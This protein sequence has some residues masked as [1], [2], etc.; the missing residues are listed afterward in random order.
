MHFETKLLIF[1]A[2]LILSNVL[3]R[4]FP[5]FPLPFIQ[6]LFGILLGFLH[7]GSAFEL[8]SEF[9]LAFVIAPINFREAQESDLSSFVKHKQMILYLILP[10]VFVTVLGLGYVAGLV[11][12]IEIPLAACFALGAALAPTDA[13]AF[14][15]IA[16]RFKFP[17]RVENIL[18]SEGLLN[19]ASGL[20]A[21]Q[22]A[23]AAMLTGVFSITQASL[24]LVWSIL[25]GIAVGFVLALLSR[26]ML[27]V[28]EKF[29]AADVTG[30]LFLEISLPLMAYFLAS[31]LGVSGIIAVVIAGVMQTYRMKKLTLFDVRVDQVSHTVWDTITFLLNGIVFIVFG[32]ELT[33]ILAPALKSSSFSNWHLLGIVLLLTSM[34][35]LIRF[36]MI[37]LF[38]SIRSIRLKKRVTRYISEILLLT[39]SGVKGTVSI[40]TILLLPTMNSLQYSLILF[41]VGAVTL[42]S[43]VT[44]LVVLPAL[45]GDANQTVNCMPQIAILTEVI[46][47]LEQDIKTSDH[48]GAIYAT[49]DNYK[50]RIAKLILEQEP[51][52][53]KRELALIQMMII[54]IETEGLEHALA[55]SQITYKE[56]QFYQFYI[57]ALEN[58]VNR[59]F[60]SNFAYSFS[61]LMRMLRYSSHSLAVIKAR[62]TQFLK[63]ERPEPVSLTKRN[64]KRLINLYKANTELVLDALDELDGVYNASLVGFFKLSRLQEVEMV[65]SDSM[66]ERIILRSITSHIDELL[67]GYYLERKLISEHEQSGRISYL[68]AREL[69][70]NVNE[71][72]SYSL[73]EASFERPN[74]LMKRFS[75]NNA[76]S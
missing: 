16:N 43:F 64:K 3:N 34:L 32:Y 40:A 60:I 66:I 55:T 68:E 52:S 46:E 31:G 59:G 14:I 24:Q 42:T 27:S 38:Y 54:G 45:A 28:L 41:I 58:R 69:R 20:V 61:I 73:K 63:Q 6:L 76:E 71:L 7:K 29:D 65:T 19:D 56:Y 50:N 51:N 2:A 36:I 18:K 26:W 9:F 72:E 25:G 10:T 15:S 1:L 8:D 22:F 37:F 30:V 70:K 44:G 17:K 33:S 62:F 4:V 5:K 23:I 48:K 53:V 67:R 74:V 75:K 11:M 35:F 39:F 47:Q 12:P 57:R 49:L 13:V 21:F